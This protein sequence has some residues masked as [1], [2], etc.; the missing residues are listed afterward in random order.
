MNITQAAAQASLLGTGFSGTYADD[1][2]ADTMTVTEARSGASTSI[3]LTSGMTTADI[4]TALT[5]AFA[6]APST[7][8]T[9]APSCTAMSP[10]PSR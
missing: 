4:V 6:A 9:P 7:R 10:A 2:S 8:S 3:Q 5:A 1:G